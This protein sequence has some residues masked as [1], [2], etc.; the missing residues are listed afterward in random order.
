MGH[1]GATTWNAPTVAKGG[2]IEYST[3]NASGLSG[4]S[5]GWSRSGANLWA[6]SILALN[7]K[8]GEMVW[9]Y[10]AVHHD[11][12][13]YDLSVQPDMINT[14]VGGKMVE[15]IE[16]TNK[17]GFV[18]DVNA[19]TGV[20]VFPTPEEEIPGNKEI[21]N[22]EE[23]LFPTQ[24]ISPIA[25][26]NPQRPSG[27]RLAEIEEALVKSAASVKEPVPKINMESG[28]KGDWTFGA[29]GSPANRR[30]KAAR[31]ARAVPARRLRASIRRPARC[32]RARS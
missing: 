14:E 9:G 17:D 28:Y 30:S 13:D 18:Y 8:T 29:I 3:A 12:W 31:E 24:P 16:Q 26:T 10:Q 5:G 6:T 19:Q 25:T 32:T 27:A 7:Y 23:A 20:P 22:D 1:G 21:Q 4:D 11:I 15:S 2:L